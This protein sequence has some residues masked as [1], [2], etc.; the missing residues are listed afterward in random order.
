MIDLLEEAKK[1]SLAEKIQLV[2]DLWDAIAEEAAQRPLTE[3]QERVLK[4]RMEARRQR[5]DQ[6]RSWEE[7]RLDV[8]GRL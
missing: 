6:S 7:V 1:L 5:P 4:A 3:A 2:E 8:E